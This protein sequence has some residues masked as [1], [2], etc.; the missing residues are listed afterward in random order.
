MKNNID[1]LSQQSTLV[2]LNTEAR[3]HTI[4][5]DGNHFMT[6]FRLLSF[7]LIEELRTNKKV[8]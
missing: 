3:Q 8:K 7:Y 5:I 6:K 1:L 4:A 2:R